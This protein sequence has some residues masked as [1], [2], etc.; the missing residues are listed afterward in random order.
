MPEERKVRTPKGSE[1][2]NGGA[3]GILAN[4]TDGYGHDDDKCNREKTSQRTLR[5]QIRDLK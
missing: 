5:S 4:L 1:P 2:A 3:S